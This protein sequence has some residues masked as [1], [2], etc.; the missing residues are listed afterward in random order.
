MLDPLSTIIKLALLNKYNNGVK[1]SIQYNIIY[2]QKKS[3]YQGLLRWFNSDSKKDLDKLFNP[4]IYA[5]QKYLI[6]NIY[7]NINI[8]FEYA[9]KGLDKLINTYNNDT[10]ISNYLKYLSLIINYFLIKFNNNLEYIINDDLI[11]KPIFNSNNMYD[12]YFNK[13]H[14]LKIDFNYINYIWTD[15]MIND[16]I[17]LFQSFYNSKLY[18][19]IDQIKKFII[20]IDLLYYKNYY[21]NI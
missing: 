6:N 8:I 13:Y 20:K 14:L 10:I 1:I 21:K 12:I 19:L 16:L 2:I 3:C 5:C 11:Y 7:P 18:I 17:I 4:I 9:I 15:T